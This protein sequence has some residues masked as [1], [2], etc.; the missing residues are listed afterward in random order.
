MNS[1]ISP[2]TKLLL[3]LIIIG[4]IGSFIGF[5]LLGSIFNT[6]SIYISFAFIIFASIYFTSDT[7]G[8]LYKFYESPVP[9]QRFVPVINEFY[10]LD[11]KYRN[12]CNVT[13]FIGTVFIAFGI[14]P[15]SIK[16]LFGNFFVLNSAFQCFFIGFF[17]FLIAQLT[18]GFGMLKTLKD[19][20]EL[21]EQI[22]KTDIG[23]IKYFG[24][25]SFIPFVRIFTFYS[26]RKP[27]DTLVVF[28]SQ[29]INSNNSVKIVDENEVTF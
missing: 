24:L 6:I 18:V 5:T 12:V 13:T 17:L 8:L 3:L 9:W 28:N 22:M 19:I 16:K 27:L 23:S 29:S 25:F 14:M 7:I 1:R 2:K 20:K 26:L 15:Y 10:I 21:W 11:R 4:I